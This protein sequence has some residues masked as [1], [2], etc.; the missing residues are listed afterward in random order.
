MIS[1]NKTK[2][3][4]LDIDGPIITS[5]LPA[6]HID[7]SSF[8]IN[9]I[10]NLLS[11]IYTTNA[12]LVTNTMH[13]AIDMNGRSIKEDLIKWG[14]PENIF[15][16][17][18]KTKFPYI[19]YSNVSSNRKGIG[20]LIAINQWLQENKTDKWVCFDDRNFTDDERLILIDPR[21]GIGNSEVI[22]ALDL[23]QS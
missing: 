2:V 5:N 3:I 8:N 19:D 10:Q 4:F 14:I 13:N 22:K 20:R 18:W 12:K 23:L 16:E 9:S 15:H 1:D 17:N 21:I 11:L 7:R 6:F